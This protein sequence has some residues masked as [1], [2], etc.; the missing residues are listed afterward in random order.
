[1]PADAEVIAGDAVTLLPVTGDAIEHVLAH[2]VRAHP[3]GAGWPSTET[4]FA[5]GFVGVGGLT[6][7]V[8]DETG[9]VVGELGT[10]GPPDADGSVEIGYGLVGASRGRGLGT[11]AVTALVD[12]LSASPDVTALVAHVAADNH[13]SQRL[14]ARL[15]FSHDGLS[16]DGEHRYVRTTPG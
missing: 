6:W 7:L 8:V 3:A 10:K 16:A 2:D 15:G 12:W 9:H 14:L 5:L 1:M 11:R 4:A 13:P